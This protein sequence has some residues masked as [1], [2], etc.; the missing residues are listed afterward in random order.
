M[1]KPSLSTKVLIGVFFGVFIGLFFGEK[2]AW[3]SIVGDVFIG[4]LQM[5]V[6]PYIM[7]SLIVNIGRLS[8]E[9]GIRLIKYGLIFL[10]LLLGLGLVFLV[11][12]PMAF[13]VW[14]SGSFYN[15]NFIQKAVDFD[16]VKL[17][18]PS[19]PFE[20]MSNS[21][22]PAVVLFSIFVGLGLMKL[23]NK[24]VLLKPLDVLISAL[25]Q[26][27]KMIV[28][29]TPLGVLAIAAGVVTK[30][31]W[32]DLSRLQAYLLIYL[33]AVML[34]TF[35]VLPYLISIFTPYSS[36]TV[37]RITKS[38]LITIFATGKIIVVFPQLIENIKEIL[39]SDDAIDDKAKSEVD[40]IMPLAYPFPNLGTLMIFVFV[41]FAAWFTGHALSWDKYPMFLSSTLL[42]SFVAPI[43]GLP[44]SLDVLKIPA[45][46]FQL[47]VV[48]TVLTDRI[49]V[50]L[51]AFHLITLSLLAIS[52]SV[53]IL[54]FKKR[55][56]ISALIVVSISVFV[57]VLGLKLLLRESIKNIPT[58]AERINQFS[59]ISPQQNYVLLD[60]PQ[61]NPNRKWRNENTLSRIKRRGKIRIGIYLNT[62]PFVFENK[63]SVLVG[64]SIDLAH[65]LA[66]D[67]GVSIEFVPITRNQ[68]ARQLNQDY[69]DIVMSDIFNSSHYSEI[70][71][72]SKSYQ[73]VS[74][75][76][77][78]PKDNNTFNNFETVSQ[79]D[80]FTISYFVREEIAQTYLSN[81]PKGGAYEIN[82]LDEFFNQ[83]NDSIKID[84]HLTSAERAASLTIFHP[85]YKLVNPLP[86]HINNGLVFPL[87]DDEVWKRY[88]D[89]WIDYRTNDGTIQKIYNEWILGEEYQKEKKKWS[90][91]SNVIMPHFETQKAKK[92]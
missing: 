2:V 33:L 28:K 80:T 89:N 15:T 71:N 34:I 66:S 84:A 50:V 64:Y 11:I 49:R 81:F 40:I 35:L 74:L 26:I 63:D 41:P 76:L 20:A 24:E 32:N 16:F 21:V 38:T 61:K 91:W 30:L 68:L 10:S 29:I 92:D 1:K 27:N 52:A 14:D 25:N 60:Y 46:S 12:L 43:T 62:M 9:S 57:S 88:I 75:A 83:Q 7:F 72:L 59:L 55:K 77:L 56:F 39:A 82:S 86:Y 36:R 42:S 53:G 6:L 4:L 44:F 85:D 51:G 65:Q 47:F 19:N 48:S 73:N 5:T 67:L 3:L 45:E 22:V 70:V 37:F 90:I 54:Q 79:L 78:V 13:P 18:I 69:F 23:P 87:A 31:S 8:L 58:N 17:Y